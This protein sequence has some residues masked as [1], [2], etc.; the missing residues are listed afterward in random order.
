[1]PLSEE[2]KAV[3]SS[4]N[5]KEAAIAYGGKT[6]V[7]CHPGCII[8]CSNIF[9]GRDGKFLTAGFEYE[10]VAMLGPNIKVFDYY[11]IGKFDFL[12]DDIGLDSIEAG[13]IIGVCMEAGKIGWGDVAG[14]EAL[15]DEMRRGTDFGKLMGEGTEILGKALGVTRIPAVKGQGVPAYDPRGFRGNGITY[16]ISTQGADHTWGMLPNP[17]ATDDEIPDLVAN[18]NINS[19]VNNDFICSFGSGALSIDPTITPDLYAGVYGGEWTMEKIRE[20]ARETI[21]IERMFNE[22]AG[23]TAADDRLPDFF[24]QAEPQFEG[25]LP[26]FPYPDELVQKNINKIYKYKD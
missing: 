17:A 2:E 25:A 6:G 16:A 19:A 3:F 15:F 10:T 24:R 14:T 18:A 1:M 5:W 20:M 22:G 13:C 21:K 11:D 26:P 12:C 7:I 9:N 4:K 8:M 23:F